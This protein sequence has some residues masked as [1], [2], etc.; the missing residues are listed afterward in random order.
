MEKEKIAELFMKGIDC[1]QVVVAAFAEELGISQEKAYKMAAGFGGG[2]GIGETC[3]AVVG[4]MIVLGLKFGHYDTEHMEQKDIMNAKRAEFLTKFQE[5]YGVC[6][7]KGLL[8][9]D[10]ADPEDMQKILDEGLLFEF[11]PEVVK[12]TIDILNEVCNG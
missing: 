8:K 7:C 5:K 9:H 11:C 10:I 3:G 4:A 6:N 1:S 2:M 12:D